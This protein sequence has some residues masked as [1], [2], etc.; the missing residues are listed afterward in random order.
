MASV[1]RVETVEEVEVRK[2]VKDSDNVEMLATRRRPR[3][4]ETAITIR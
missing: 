2:E 4:V 1:P 3:P